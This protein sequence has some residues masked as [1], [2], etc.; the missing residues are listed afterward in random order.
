MSASALAASGSLALSSLFQGRRWTVTAALQ[1]EGLHLLA[2]TILWQAPHDATADKWQQ[3]EDC[4]AI[5]DNPGHHA[6]KS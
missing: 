1:A 2:T 5:R 3:I 6:D 4:E